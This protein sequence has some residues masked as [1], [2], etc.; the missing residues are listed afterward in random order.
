MKPTQQFVYT[1]FILSFFLKRKKGWG[2]IQTIQII[3]A[4]L[5]SIEFKPLFSTFYFIG[6]FIFG[7]DRAINIFPQSSVSNIFR[8]FHP[9]KQEI[10][11]GEFK[12]FYFFF[13]CFIAHQLLN[14]CLN[15]TFQIIF[16]LILYCTWLLQYYYAIQ[17]N[18]KL[19][20]TNLTEYET[21]EWQ[22]LIFSSISVCLYA[23]PN[24]Y[25]IRDSYYSYKIKCD[26]VGSN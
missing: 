11:T 24:A 17:L 8:F 9:Q 1:Y 4:G 16:F 18:L 25:I 15:R 22:Q 2:N 14:V 21:N 12:G 6:N 26:P 19:L 23:I 20:T 7:R 3:N 5:R 13:V 10:S